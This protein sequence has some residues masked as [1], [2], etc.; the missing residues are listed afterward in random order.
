MNIQFGTGVLI[1]TP[2]VGQ[3]AANPGPR[4]FPILQEVS[5][6]FKGDVKEL[7]GMDQIAEAVA[8][9]KIKISGKGKIIVPSPD[10]LSQLF[11]GLP[12]SSGMNRPVFNESHAT[13]ASVAPS[14]VTAATD[15][16]VI[17]GGNGLPMIKVTSGSPTVGQY[18]FTPYNLTGPVDASYAFNASETAPTVLLNYEWPDTLGTS[19]EI[20]SQLMGVSPQVQMVLFNTFRNK[21]FALQLNSCVLGSFSIPTKQEDF[22]L[23]DFDFMASKD[24]A[25]VVGIFSADN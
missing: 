2:N 15:L 16:G 17:N 14:E 9:G 21:Q 19:L 7:Y 6:E 22:W 5:V 20:T 4:Q 11:F 8:R 25:G 1:A 13:A 23:S 3:L 12:T 18:K 10:I 24:D